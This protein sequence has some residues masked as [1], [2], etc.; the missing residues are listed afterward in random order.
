MMRSAGPAIGLGVCLLGKRRGFAVLS[1]VWMLPFLIP[2]GTL[3]ETLQSG[4]RVRPWA[5]T[6]GGRRWSRRI[7]FGCSCTSAVYRSRK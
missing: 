1:A 2:G 5:I 6:G 7:G 4:V 3:L